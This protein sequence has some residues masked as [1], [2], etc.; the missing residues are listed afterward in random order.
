M[1][2]WN[3]SGNMKPCFKSGVLNQWYAYHWWYAKAFL[4]VR[5]MFFQKCK[6]CICFHRNSHPEQCSNVNLVP[7]HF[8]LLLNCTT[9]TLNTYIYVRCC[10]LLRGL[11]SSD[12]RFFFLSIAY[13]QQQQAA[14][15]SKILASVLRNI[16]SNKLTFG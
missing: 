14:T 7:D 13:L 10:I 4:V 16:S 2:I 15:R 11:D 3:A 8:L 6:K 1:C 5:E 9:Y 12:W